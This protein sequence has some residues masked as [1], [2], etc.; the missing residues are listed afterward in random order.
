MRVL[1]V[2][3]SPR[4][5][6]NTEGLLRVALEELEKH[7]VETELLHLADHQVKPC[8]GCYGCVQRG[9]GTCVQNDPEFDALALRFHDLDGLLLGSP[10]YFGSATAQ[11]SALM[12]RVAFLNRSGGPNHLSRKVGASIAVARRAG[13]N[14]T[15][16]QLNYYFG[17]LDMVTVGSTYWNIGIA[18]QA[19]DFAK[20]EEGVATIRRLGENL[21]W[22]L[23]KLSD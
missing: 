14:F 15:F 23:E 18:R 5:N 22:L 20:D 21:A 8:V 12:D 11:L 1:A 3:G 6:G 2:C 4:K 17:I 19:G 16:A 7:N 9:D 10:V 13:E